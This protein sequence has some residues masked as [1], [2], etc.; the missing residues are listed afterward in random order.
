MENTDEVAEHERLKHYWNYKNVIATA[1]ADGIKAG[2]M[3][4]YETYILNG[5]EAGFSPD[6]LAKLTKLT[7]AEVL[8]IIQRGRNLKK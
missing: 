2:K 5:H 7:V 4:A 1:Y 6:S 3:E 8:K